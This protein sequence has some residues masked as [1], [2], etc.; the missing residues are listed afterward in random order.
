MLRLY[1]CLRFWT[2][3]SA[4]VG[5]LAVLLLSKECTASFFAKGILN[6]GQL[7]LYD[8]F[9]WILIACRCC[10]VSDFLEEWQNAETS[11]FFKNSVW[12]GVA[13][14]FSWISSHSNSW[15]TPTTVSGKSSELCCCE[16]LSH[17]PGLYRRQPGHSSRFTFTV[18]LGTVFW[19]AHSCSGEVWDLLWKQ[20]CLWALFKGEIALNNDLHSLYSAPAVFIAS[21]KMCVLKRFSF[22]SHCYS[23]VLWSLSFL[24]IQ[25]LPNF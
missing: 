11:I 13:R 17:P 24:G 20:I 6:K 19:S 4:A 8:V 21:R 9:I 7:A 10:S 14:A 3:N 2:L 12:K 5:F 25:C 18:S 1:W 16:T 22:L 15:T 23:T